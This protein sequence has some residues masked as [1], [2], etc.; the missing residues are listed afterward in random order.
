MILPFIPEETDVLVPLYLTG[1]KKR[2]GCRRSFNSLSPCLESPINSKSTCGS[3][4]L[5]HR[6]LWDAG[7][8]PFR[9]MPSTLYTSCVGKLGWTKASCQEAYHPYP[10]ESTPAVSPAAYITNCPCPSGL[11]DFNLQQEFR[12]QP[13][14]LMQPYDILEEERVVSLCLF[15]SVSHNY[16]SRHTVNNWPPCSPW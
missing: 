3:N 6:S 14:T 5:Q 8:H 13:Q 16:K 2:D 7:P 11:H 12:E 10:V 15:V 9:I 4:S 1:C